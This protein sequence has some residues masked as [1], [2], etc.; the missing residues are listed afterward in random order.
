MEN[1][2]SSEKLKTITSIGYGIGAIGEGIG[3]NVFFSFFSFFLTTIAGIQPA[4]AGVD[5]YKR[6]SLYT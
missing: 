3:Y 6:Q 1:K 5:V 2:S 4:I